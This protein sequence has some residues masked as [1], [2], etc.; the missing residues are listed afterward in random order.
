MKKL[1]QFLNSRILGT[2]EVISLKFGLW[3]TEV[4]GCVHSK[5]GL[6]L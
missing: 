5:I 3:C 2:L 1:S 6:V 4:G